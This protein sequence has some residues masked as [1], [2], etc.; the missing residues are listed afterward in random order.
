MSN[1][2]PFHWNAIWN[3]HEDD[4]C[5]NKNPTLKHVFKSLPLQATE[6]SYFVNKKDHFSGKWHHVN[7]QN[8]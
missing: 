3:L 1:T 2:H 4:N 7:A 8:Y 5:I 6:W